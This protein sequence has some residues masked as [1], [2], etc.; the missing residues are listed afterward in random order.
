MRLSYKKYFKKETFRGLVFLNNSRNPI[1]IKRS[2]HL[3][4]KSSEY[5]YISKK[6]SDLEFRT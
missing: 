4:F 5:T 3:S 1:L 6:I 2:I